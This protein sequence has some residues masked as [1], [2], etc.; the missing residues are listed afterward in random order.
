MENTINQ[1]LCEQCKLCIEVCPVNIIAANKQGQV[2]F[3]R[4]REHICLECG[5]CM[6]IC[7]TKAIQVNGYS[8]EKDLFDLPKATV[9]YPQLIDFLS[10]RRSV[11]N[12][13]DKPVPDEMIDKI[14][15][16]I[17][18]AP[19]GSKPEKMH[20]TV[21]NDRKKIEAILPGI[22]QFLNNIVKWVENPIISYFIRRKTGNETF[23]TIKNHLYPIAKT[24]NYKLKYGDRITRGAPAILVFHAEAG[25]EEHTNNSMIYATYAM[26]A[27]QS[28]GL[29]A[30]II[31]L[32]P[33][34]INK[35]KEVREKFGIPENHEAVI[36]V[37]IGYPKY[38]YKRGIKREKYQVK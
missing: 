34:A 3:I 14:I 5:Q 16:A 37:I 17:D 31:G 35:M 15:A 24:G 7:T 33:P 23:N 12:F 30:T 20:I 29:G 36:S 19:Y 11:R 32:V 10:H 6:A 8:Y 27:A 9:E 25:A 18:F 1:S 38:K 21:V 28:L 4:E 26:M 13:K 2:N 22:E